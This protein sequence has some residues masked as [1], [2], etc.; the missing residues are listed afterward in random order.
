MY[1]YKFQFIITNN[2]VHK[3][4]LNMNFVSFYTNNTMYA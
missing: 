2:F 4:V 3:F 1:M